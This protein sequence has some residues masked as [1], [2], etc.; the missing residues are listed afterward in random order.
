MAADRFARDPLGR[1][2]ELWWRRQVVRAL[3]GILWLQD[4]WADRRP[5]AAA[6]AP[7][8]HRVLFLRPDRIGD[9]I[10]T[11]GV[12]RAIGSAPAVAL[13]VLASPENAAVLAFLAE[14]APDDQ[15]HSVWE[16]EYEAVNVF[17]PGFLRQK[18]AYIH[19]NPLQSRWQLAD[20]AEQYMWS[21]ARYYLANKRTVIPISDARKLM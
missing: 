14:A 12:L 1:R 7:V 19:H 5:R 8:T 18:M 9:M 10:V 2:L 11:T 16:T 17:T 20:R 15:E 6:A 13:D 21:S 3:T 4:R